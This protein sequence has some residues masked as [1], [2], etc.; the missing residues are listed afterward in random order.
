MSDLSGRAPS[1]PLT[2]E[3]DAELYEE[4]M[5]TELRRQPVNRLAIATLISGLLGGFL[6]PIF[7]VIALIQVKKRRQR[8]KILAVC[9]MAAFVFWAALAVFQVST[10]RAWWQHDPGGGIASGLDLAVQDC[11]AA[12]AMSGEVSVAR[13]PCTD[14][15]TGEA[16]AVVP[17]PDG[18]YPDV[19]ELYRSSLARCQSQAA[20]SLGAVANR[21]DV[22]IQVMTPTSYMWLRQPHHVVCYFNFQAGVTRPV[23]ELAAG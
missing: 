10:G 12:P 9:G 1:V 5:R 13:L 17:L 18:P 16:F 15:H 22:R 19:L 11:F 3:H 21:S 6:A 20:T 14:L 2:P 8:G 7:G 23:R 4:L